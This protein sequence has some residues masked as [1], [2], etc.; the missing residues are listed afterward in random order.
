MCCVARLPS[1]NCSV[2]K[3]T[4]AVGLVAAAPVAVVGTTPTPISGKNLLV[5]RF[6]ASLIE[7]MPTRNSLEIPF[8]RF[9]N[10]CTVLDLLLLTPMNEF[11]P[12]RNPLVCDSGFAVK[13]LLLREKD[14]LSVRLIS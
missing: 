12:R 11:D 6:R 7:L 14:V 8:A 9:E 4:T 10:S 3:V 13:V 5:G 2:P 1:E